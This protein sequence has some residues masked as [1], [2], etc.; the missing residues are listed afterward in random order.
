MISEMNA[1][2]PINIKHVQNHRDIL[3]IIFVHHGYTK[4]PVTLAV[5]KTHL[6]KYMTIIL[7]TI[8]VQ[9]C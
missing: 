3:E 6:K 2:C 9:T 4:N 5:S 7:G 1:D 8:L